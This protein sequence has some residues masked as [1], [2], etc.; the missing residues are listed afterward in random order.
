MDR[1]IPREGRKEVSFLFFVFSSLTLW[2]LVLVLDKLTEIRAEPGKGLDRNVS[3]LLSFF[4]GGQGRIMVGFTRVSY[5]TCRWMRWDFPGGGGGVSRWY[6]M[7]R[8]VGRRKEGRKEEMNTRA[9]D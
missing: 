3:F 1:K 7:R 2:L 4:F 9:I 5:D 6:G 8:R